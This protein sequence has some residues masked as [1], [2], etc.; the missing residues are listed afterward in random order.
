MPT[1]DPACPPPP[2]LDLAQGDLLDTTPAEPM[3]DLVLHAAAVRET[4]MGDHAEFT[5]VQL[6]V[7]MTDTVGDLLR[8]AGLRR[9]VD[10]L[11]LQVDGEEEPHPI[12]GYGHQ[13]PQ[14]P[15]T[16]PWAE[17]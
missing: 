17:L 12:S 5:R 10:R 8:R 2:S 16:D 1:P 13:S 9:P 6:Q 15:V 14:A 7:K 4:Y 3:P 11:E